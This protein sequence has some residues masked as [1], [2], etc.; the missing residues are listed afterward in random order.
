M[1]AE[2]LHRRRHR[3]DATAQQ[4]P[5]SRHRSDATAET[6]SRSMGVSRPK[7][8]LAEAFRAGASIGV[9]DPAGAHGSERE[10]TRIVL[11][12]PVAQIVG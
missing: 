6:A 3:S 10:Q 11:L 2:R 1:A 12:G 9:A 8:L 7:A 4:A 5:H